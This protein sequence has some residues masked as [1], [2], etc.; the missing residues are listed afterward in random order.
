MGREEITQSIIRLSQ[1]AEAAAEDG[2]LPHAIQTAFTACELAETN[3]GRDDPLHAD[4]LQELAVLLLRTAQEIGTQEA[5]RLLKQVLGIRVSLYGD[6]H[7]SLAD[8]FMQLGQAQRQAG[9]RESAETSLVQALQIRLHA[10]GTDSPAVQDAIKPLTDLYLETNLMGSG[11]SPMELQLKELT[12]D[13]DLHRVRQSPLLEM[14][15]F[16]LNN[17]PDMIESRE[18]IESFLLQSCYRL[19]H[20]LDSLEERA[21]GAEPPQESFK[22]TS[23][24]ASSDLEKGLPISGPPTNNLGNLSLEE[25]TGPAELVRYPALDAPERTPINQKFS[26][27]VGLWLEAPEPGV[28]SVVVQDTGIQLPEV[29][30]VLRAPGFEI[31][32]GGSN[33]RLLT[34]Q[35]E[36]DSEIR[37]VLT[38]TRLGDGELRVDFYQFNKRLATL[39]RTLLVFDP[40]A[41]PVE[42]SPPGSLAERLKP[43]IDVAGPSL[44]SHVIAGPSLAL[45]TSP[46]GPV[47]DLELNVQIESWERRAIR[48]SLNGGPRPGGGYHYHYQDAGR[49]DLTGVIPLI[50]SP[51]ADTIPVELTSVYQELGELAHLGLGNTRAVG[52]ARRQKPLVAVADRKHAEGRLTAIGNDLWDHF[53]SD[54]LKQ[55]YW[56]FKKFAQSLL[57]T[58]NEPWIPWEMVR[59]YRIN[60]KGQRKQDPFWCQQFAIS[61]WLAGPGYADRLELRSGLAR[62][63]SPQQVDLPAVSGELEYFDRLVKLQP[64]ITPLPPIH[65]RNEA[66]SWLNQGNFT[67]AH[68]ACHGA[69]VPGQP[70]ASAIELSGGALRPSDIQ[71]NYEKAGQRPLIFVNACHGGRSQVALTGIGGWARALIQAE[72]AAFLGAQWEVHDK[73]ALEFMQTFYTELLKEKTSLAEAVRKARE[74]IRKRAPYNSTWLAYILYANP[75]MGIQEAENA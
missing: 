49:I 41:P 28:A 14:I 19:Q 50:N 72:V 18:E 10:F 29:E 74:T 60:R 38:P 51:D 48:F 43:A 58:T 61:R 7:P 25:K 69:F 32:D 37:F 63:V 16:S 3:L 33:T 1:Q 67:L 15:E 34:V 6:R 44:P 47:P 64:G 26:L 55:E 53:I 30:L 73:L 45:T 8:T 54:S 13:W 68:F 22:E 23:S 40:E 75:E 65:Q 27:T 39:R 5:I 12:S 42:I 20:L 35:R 70:D 66:I 11:M 57:I 56:K 4:C 36:E 17:I 31:S 46:T 2:D 62:P 71:I 21:V 24:G 59:P 9:D 52:S